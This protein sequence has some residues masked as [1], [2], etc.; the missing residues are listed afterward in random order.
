MPADCNAIR[1]SDEMYCATCRL[2]WDVMEPTICGRE[3]PSIV[4]DD[5]KVQVATRNAGERLPFK[6]GLPD[7]LC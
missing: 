6:S 5:G 2:R 4:P 1:Q 3:C 7:N